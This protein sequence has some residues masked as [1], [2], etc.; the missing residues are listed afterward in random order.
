MK[1]IQHDGTA[2]LPIGVILNSSHNTTLKQQDIIKPIEAK[3]MMNII[4]IYIPLAA[5]S[6]LSNKS[7]F[8]TESFEGGGVKNLV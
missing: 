7:L 1:N 3:T 5:Y 2:V 4:K 6:E 8:T